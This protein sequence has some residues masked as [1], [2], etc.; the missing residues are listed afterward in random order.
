[1]TPRPSSVPVTLEEGGSDDM[2]IETSD[3]TQSMVKEPAV[4]AV[5]VGEVKGKGFV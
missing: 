3:D 4:K 1:M 5:V 2:V